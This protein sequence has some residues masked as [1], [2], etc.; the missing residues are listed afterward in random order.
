MAQ[1]PRKS[2]FSLTKAS[3]ESINFA[4]ISV[5]TPA[6][7]TLSEEDQETLE[8]PDASNRLIE[9]YR[10][11]LNPL[12][13]VIIANTEFV[14]V[15]DGTSPDSTGL[16]AQFGENNLV[17]VNSV[18]KLF[19]IHRQIRKAMLTSAESLLGRIKQFD[20]EKDLEVIRKV[21]N[22]NFNDIVKENIKDTVD[23]AIKLLSSGGIQQRSA[24]TSENT[25]KSKSGRSNFSKRNSVKTLVTVAAA[26]NRNVRIRK[27][28]GERA[29]TD[30]F[31]RTLIEFV[32][33]EKL[34]YS[35]VNYMSGVASIKVAAERSWSVYEALSYTTNGQ[36]ASGSSAV[37]K[38]LELQL[39][40]LDDITE[41]FAKASGPAVD[42]VKDLTGIKPQSETPD[43]ALLVQF[44]VAAADSILRQSENMS[45]VYE[46][47]RTETR[48]RVNKKP[49]YGKDTHTSSALRDLQDMSLQNM[50]HYYNYPED[51]EFV[52]ISDVNRDNSNPMFGRKIDDL[53]DYFPSNLE[54]I[55]IHGEML[56][57]SLFD[58]CVSIAS[59]TADSRIR[60][61]YSMGREVPSGVRN[62]EDYFSR[63]INYRKN[64]K[65]DNREIELNLSENQ[66]VQVGSLFKYLKTT[67]SKS[68]DLSFHV[69]LES[70]SNL[71]EEISNEPY[72]T[73]PEYFYDIAL[74]RG[75]TSL[76]DLREFSSKYK[77]VG[78]SYVEDIYSMTKLDYLLPTTKALLKDIGEDLMRSATHNDSLFLLALISWKASTNGGIMDLMR[79]IYPGSFLTS[80]S[81]NHD[82]QDV[83]DA[84]AAYLTNSSLSYAIPSITPITFGNRRALR[85]GADSLIARLLMDGGEISWSDIKQEKTGAKRDYLGDKLTGASRGIQG[86]EY[87]N[88]D[89]NFGKIPEGKWLN[90]VNDIKNNNKVSYKIHKRSGARHDSGINGLSHEMFILDSGAGFTFN[91]SNPNLTIRKYLHNEYFRESGLASKSEIED[92]NSKRSGRSYSSEDVDTMIQAAVRGISSESTSI[93]IY[94]ALCV[95]AQG[96]AYELGLHHRLFLLYS[97]VAKILHKSAEVYIDSDY[98]DKGGK[99]ALLKLTMDKTEIQGIAQAFIDAAEE[100][101][102]NNKAS[103]S[104]A[105]GEAYQNTRQHLRRFLNTIQRK[106]SLTAALAVA[107]ALHAGQ[108]QNQFKAAKKFLSAGDGTSSGTLAIN[109]LKSRKI[110]V[111][112]KSLSLITDEAVLQ[113]YKSYVNSMRMSKDYSFTYE[114]VPSL[115]QMKLMMKIL[116]QSGYGL[117]SSE[118]RGPKNICHV[119]ITNSMLN[120]LRLEAFKEFD[121]RNFLNA[122]RFCVNVFKKNE[123][124]SQILVYPKTFLFDSTVEILDSD[125]TGKSLNHITNYSD[126]WTF[127]NIVDNIEYTQA[128]TGNFS[129]SSDPFDSLTSSL[130]IK[131]TIGTAQIDQDVLINHLFDYAFKAYYR[132]ALGID[133]NENTFTL[134]PIRKNTGVVNGGLSTLKRDIQEDYDDLINQTR[135]LYPAA[136]VDQKLASELFRTIES[137]AAHPGYCLI[138]KVQKVVYPKK[139]DKVVSFLINEKDFILFTDAYEKEFLDVYKTSPNFSYTSRIARPETKPKD[140]DEDAQITSINKYIRECEE[141]FPE[142]FSTYVTITILPEN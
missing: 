104:E 60:M 121:N 72:L 122:K 20:P 31:L 111:F 58:D 54:E 109:T 101:F 86:N 71:K 118:K 142:V 59:H 92:F 53:Y 52:F 7:G 57:A 83:G 97:F 41:L 68:D 17:S 99:D 98:G 94:D 64:Y 65:K 90:K 126:S 6:A 35:I 136:N 112:E 67:S 138:D 78:N 5:T 39:L 80:H 102:P 135:L 22:E 125:H 51:L 63:L 45:E 115:T 128:L 88:L 1:D 37:T 70:T 131:H 124:D 10:Q 12:K 2:T 44:F 47:A 15:S 76:K 14:P 28:I 119:G 24:G 84:A 133:L 129:D 11:G 25:E 117:L 56:A 134:N 46:G 74:Q 103:F 66:G 42:V 75:D 81:K 4:T 9:L 120:T 105:G 91:K 93:N 62:I 100:A 33:L 49:K 48:Y 23:E 110:G 13:P 123:I 3:A 114:D 38:M 139:F 36:A 19:E 132:Y 116:S 82:G 26:A 130:K 113:M 27:N 106:I 34:T 108:I 137:I 141:S 29:K 21:I 8:N 55:D 79:S 50:Y 40:G 61:F 30:I 96:T 77:E 89:K 127:Q 87:V 85:L 107:P 16:K 140:S 69:P 32:I 43:V 18:V 73:G 95:A